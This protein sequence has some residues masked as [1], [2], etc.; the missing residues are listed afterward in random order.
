MKILVFLIVLL[1]IFSR[2]LQAQWTVSGYSE[3]GDTNISEGV[4]VKLVPMLCYKLKNTQMDVVIRSDFKENHSNFISGYQV[5]LA[6]NF[7]LS[8]SLYKVETF[9]MKTAPTELMREKNWGIVL[10]A[11]KGHFDIKA[12]TNLKTIGHSK[13]AIKEYNLPANDVLRENLNLM[14]QVTYDLRSALKSWNIGA[15]WT[16]FDHL[17]IYQ[18]TNPVINIHGYYRLKQQIRLFAEVWYK[19]AGAINL[20]VNYY[21]SSL[22][23]GFIWNLK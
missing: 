4:Y 13:Q 7:R 17:C 14:Y 5:N 22:R 21:S 9:Y 10:S 16:N 8:N 2:S 15:T 20:S 18:E 19:T 1:L 6:Q 12:G 11:P 3:F 23:T